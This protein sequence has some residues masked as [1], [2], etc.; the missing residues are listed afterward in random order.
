[1]ILRNIHSMSWRQRSPVAKEPTMS[2]PKEFLLILCLLALMIP[3][4]GIASP[5][6]KAGSTADSAV[7]TAAGNTTILQNAAQKGFPLPVVAS[8]SNSAS[9]QAVLIP[10]DL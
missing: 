2:T 8:V 6:Q 1:M 10:A 7:A 4:A 5:Q 3:R 9:N